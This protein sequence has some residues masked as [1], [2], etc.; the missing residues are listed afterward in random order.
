MLRELY[1]NDLS[2]PST[3][4]PSLRIIEGAWDHGRQTMESSV[5]LVKDRCF[6]IAHTVA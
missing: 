3:E 2:I 1:V 4:S 5:L 6:S